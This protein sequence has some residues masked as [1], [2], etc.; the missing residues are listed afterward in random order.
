MVHALKEAH[1]V[2]VPQGTM[3]DV[4]PLGVDIPL[5]VL[6]AGGIES[7]GIV[8]MSPGAH[9]DIASDRAIDFVLSAGLFREIKVEFFDFALY[10][11]TVKDMEEDIEENW[12]DE[13]NI[14]AETWQRARELVDKRLPE[15]R[16]RVALRMKM[17][18][19]EKCG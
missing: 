10:W 3:I 5:M 14:S 15:T 11:N 7:A 17:G 2:L 4:R 19:Y 6:Y 8:D 9:S 1:R 16:I 18:K 12:E 13:V